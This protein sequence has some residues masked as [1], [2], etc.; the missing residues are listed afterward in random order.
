MK[1]WMAA[2]LAAAMMTAMC[3]CG[4]N[5]ASNG[6]G[7]SSS[8]VSAAA[9]TTSELTETSAVQEIG[10]SIPDVQTAEYSKEQLYGMWYGLNYNGRAEIDGL[11]VE[12]KSLSG[13]GK[14]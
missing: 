2:V 4:G 3:G 8:D 10:E 12:V 7:S 13:S 5:E 9:S 11:S 1:K 6:G 14:K